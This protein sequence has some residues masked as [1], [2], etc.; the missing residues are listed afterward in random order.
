MIINNDTFDTAGA[1]KYKYKLFGDDSIGE[2]KFTLKADYM[3]SSM[4]HNTGLASFIG[5]NL[6]DTHV[7]P[8]QLDN[9]VRSCCKGYP[10]LLYIDGEYAGIYNFMIDKGAEETFGFKIPKD[11]A[12]ITKDIFNKKFPCI[13]GYEGSANSDNTAGAFRAWKPESG[14]SMDSWYASDFE[15]RYPDPDDEPNRPYTEIHRLVDFVDN[16]SD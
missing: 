15:L 11:R 16:A 3:D 1:V 7:P 4:S 13:I 9:R 2:Y 10:F 12:D 6:Y 14:M 8:H 5:D